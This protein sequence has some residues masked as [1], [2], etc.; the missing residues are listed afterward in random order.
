M[1][2]SHTVASDL[3]G[4]SPADNSYTTKEP[5]SQ[6]IVQCTSGWKTRGDKSGILTGGWIHTQIRQEWSHLWT[7]P[8]SSEERIYPSSMNPSSIPVS[9]WVGHCSASMGARLRQTCISPKLVA[10]RICAQWPPDCGSSTRQMA[11]RFLYVVSNLVLVESVKSSLG[12]MVSGKCCL[13]QFIVIGPI[14][15]KSV[16]FANE[17]KVW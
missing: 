7:M 1:T 8:F 17:T 16:A 13:L 11:H 15:P 3:Y 10:S 4:A 14:S 5:L 12:M 2:L 6:E 9:S